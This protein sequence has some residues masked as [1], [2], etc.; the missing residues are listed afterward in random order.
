MTRTSPNPPN[1]AAASTQP[2]QNAPPTKNAKGANEPPKGSKKP[3]KVVIQDIKNIPPKDLQFK[4]DQVSSGVGGS[5]NISIDK[6][7]SGTKPEDMKQSYWTHCQFAFSSDMRGVIKH[8]GL[9]LATGGLYAL[10]GGSYLLVRA[11]V[12]RG[13]Q[14]GRQRL[15]DNY[16]ENLS[17][18]KKL[19]EEEQVDLPEINTDDWNAVLDFRVNRL[20]GFARRGFTD[21]QRETLTK[22]VVD[23]LRRGGSV[24]NAKNFVENMNRKVRDPNFDAKKFKKELTRS[25]LY[26]ASR[27]GPEA[28]VQFSI[29]K[30]KA[31]AQ[32]IEKLPSDDELKEEMVLSGKSGEQILFFLTDALKKAGGI[33]EDT[34]G[35]LNYE[36]DPHLPSKEDGD[37][38]SG[39]QDFSSGNE[40]AR[41]L[42]LARRSY[43]R[44]VH[45]LIAKGSQEA[46]DSHK[47]VLDT[48][49]DQFETARTKAF[50]DAIEETRYVLK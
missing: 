30:H 19:S 25:D 16:L 26:F 14:D 34:E 13:I 3:Q 20:G 28:R 45:G 38:L 9:T 27:L 10:I 35:D 48:L 4:S 50:E 44:L 12:K 37:F 31:L 32:E 46:L 5:S 15:R 11:A 7:L 22:T 1:T 36:V 29:K 8:I 24:D 39:N 17:T 42:R 41:N 2:A 47:K 43:N 23:A 18:K 40:M 21:E 6:V 33:I 49:D